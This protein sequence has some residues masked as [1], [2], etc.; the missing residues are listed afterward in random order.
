MAVWTG[1]RRTSGRLWSTRYWYYRALRESLNRLYSIDTKLNPTLSYVAL[2]LLHHYPRLMSAD[3]GKIPLG[4]LYHNCLGVLA[5][6]KEQQPHHT[7]N[8]F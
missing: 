4:S 1:K 3:Y 6:D 8:K 7:L 5:I 2:S